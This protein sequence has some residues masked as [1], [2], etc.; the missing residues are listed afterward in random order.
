MAETTDRIAAAFSRASSSYEDTAL[1]QREV[2]IRLASRIDPRCI[3]AHPRVLEIGA[4]TG[5]LSTRLLDAIPGGAWLLTDISE[6]MLARCRERILDPRAR[7]AV[8]SGERPPPGRY[9]LVVSSLA[10]QWLEDIESGLQRLSRCLAPGGTLA[11]ATLGEDTFRE[12]IGAHSALGLP[13][14]VRTYPSAS[15]LG[16][17]W[18]RDG[19]GAVDEERIV[20][21]YS[22]ARSFLR[23]L[24]AI[25]ASTPRS[26]HRPLS[27][28]ALKRVLE[29]L[30][31]DCTLTYHVLYGRFVARGAGA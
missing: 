10:L 24:K 28:S 4:G 22:D 23:T 9:D 29:R 11:F 19:D 17:M 1:V 12:W 6:G 25:G 30:G 8:A 21:P 15:E 26:G 2:A 5:F 7:F 27:P 14:G 31:P 20:V 16:R 18:P 3:A 13:S